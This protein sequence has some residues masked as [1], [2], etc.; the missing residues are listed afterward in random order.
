[1]KEKLIFGIISILMLILA[2]CN[3]N[4]PDGKWDDNIKLSEKEVTI[5]AAS[6]AL[7]ITTKGTWW[8][9]NGIALDDDWSYDIS[10]ID[11]SKED[12]LIEEN[13]FTIERKNATEI[14]ISLTEN[15]TNVER[16]LT[17]GLQAGNYFD[18]I[19]I[20]QVGK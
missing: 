17:I 2:S 10:D 8:W 3:S 16:I 14:H 6:K 20:I 5:S 4:E 7:I 19:K 15:K 12:F 13:E 18:G 11:T 9:I 1:M